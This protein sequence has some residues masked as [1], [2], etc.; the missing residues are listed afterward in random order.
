M[1]IPLPKQ[2][3]LRTVQVISG[4]LLGVAWLKQTRLFTV[5]F[6]DLKTLVL[7]I[8]TAILVLILVISAMANHLPDR[9]KTQL[10]PDLLCFFSLF[11]ITLIA[12][13]QLFTAKQ[14]AMPKV[15][16]GLIFIGLALL[17]AYVPR[18][19]IIG[20]RLSAFITL[21][22][23]NQRRVNLLAAR[24]T[25]VVGIGCLVTATFS[26]SIFGLTLF[27]TTLALLV[28]VLIVASKLAE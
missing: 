9:L 24:L 18:N 5:S 19:P 6:N 2:L 1:I 8:F 23:Q 27:V 3:S 11:T 7:L 26:P 22:P 28:G 25:L 10:P 12:Y 14:L 16:T 21:S 4:V 17:T 20:V 13:P 15:D